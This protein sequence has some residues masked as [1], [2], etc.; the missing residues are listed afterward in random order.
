MP[1]RRLPTPVTDA[2]GWAALLLVCGL[3]AG[4]GGRQPTVGERDGA[5]AHQ[6]D[7]SHVQ[8][9]VPR[10]EPKS[11]GGNPPSY[12]VF[13]R[14][15]HVMDSSRGHVERGIASWYGTKFHG[16][17]TSNGETYDMYAMTAAHKH[18]PLPTYARVTNLE[19]GRSIVVRVNDR[20]PFHD[21]RVIDLSYAAAYKLGMLAKGTAAVEVQAIDPRNPQLAAAG[22][23]RPRPSTGETRVYLQA[24]AFSSETNARRLQHRLSRQLEQPV[25]VTANA[26]GVYRV[27]IGPLPTAGELDAVAERLAGL[28]IRD[29]HVVID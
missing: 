8:D 2:R 13:G 9:A 10:I 6:P 14:R 27:Q 23:P 26:P 20:G 16:R 1:T 3:L 11:R 24:G 25:R 22:E 5:P 18:L 29:S 28:G 19:N 15:Y 17:K 12:V 4:C 21:N 7:L